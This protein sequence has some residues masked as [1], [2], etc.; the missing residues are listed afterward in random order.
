MV[1]V[2]AWLKWT[3]LALLVLLG[4]FA[5]GYLL[6]TRLLFPRPDTVGGGVAVPS[7]YG[8]ERE[9]AERTLT[10][11]G[12]RVGTVTEVASMRVR[13]GR[14]VAQEPIPEQH[15]RPGAE[16]SLAVSSGSPAV[17]VPPVM[18]LGERTARELLE[19]AGFEV[20]VRE[21]RGGAVA[22][23]RVLGTEPQAGE[24]VRLPAEIT[25]VVIVGREDIEPVDSPAVDT[26]PAP[27]P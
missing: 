4:S 5:V 9:A 18:G 21:V 22:P 27:W 13:S 20:G 1:D 6:A 17:R 23:G 16:V 24:V 8:E 11:L 2:P 19:A 7:L 14:V 15:L 10:A 12:L 26:V 3:G 25:L